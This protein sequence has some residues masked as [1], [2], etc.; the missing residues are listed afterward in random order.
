MQDFSAL[1]ALEILAGAGV[2][3]DALAFFEEQGHLD[4]RAGLQLGG[5]GGVE[6]VVNNLAVT[7]EKL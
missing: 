7:V 1:G 6:S 2:D 5:L 4:L 3:L